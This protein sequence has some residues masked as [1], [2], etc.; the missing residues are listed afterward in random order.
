MGQP[1]ENQTPFGVSKEKEL[2]RDR[3]ESMARDDAALA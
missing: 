2:T 1:A 3:V